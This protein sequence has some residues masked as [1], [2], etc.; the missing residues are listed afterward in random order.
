MIFV[1]N[2]NK[3]EI[4]MTMTVNNECEHIILLG[5]R[6]CYSQ[7]SCKSSHQSLLRS[8]DYSSVDIRLLM[9][10]QLGVDIHREPEAWGP[11]CDVVGLPGGNPARNLQG[12]HLWQRNICPHRCDGFH[13]RRKSTEPGLCF[14]WTWCSETL[15]ELYPNISGGELMFPV[16]MWGGSCY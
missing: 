2:N 16:T 10:T 7:R 3:A 12:R 9:L 4:T 6:F 11:Q 14:A 13:T 5:T 15:E 1:L 8:C